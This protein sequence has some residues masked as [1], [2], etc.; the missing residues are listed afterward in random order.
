[1]A[2]I[3][4][5]FNLCASDPEAG[6]ELI[7]FIIREEPEVESE[8]I[9]KFA[10][11]MVYASKGLRIPQGGLGEEF[12]PTDQEL[13]YLE[14]A[15]LRIK[16]IEETAP[17]FLQ[18]L[19]VPE[20]GVCRARVN[21]VVAALERHKPGR[22]QE[23][24]GEMKFKYD[25]FLADLPIEEKVS[26]I[27]NL[28]ESDPDAALRIL[29]S[30]DIENPLLNFSKALA[31]GSKGLFQ[32]T[33]SKP[34]VDITAASGKELREELGL[35]DKQLDY[36]ELALQE[37]KGLEDAHPGFVKEMGT[38]A[39]RKVDVMAIALERC[40][41][42]RVQ[43][44]LGKTKL[45]YFGPERIFKHEDCNLTQQEFQFFRNIFF[46]CRGIAKSALLWLNAIDAEGRRYLAV[47]LFKEPRIFNEKR[48]LSPKAGYVVLYE[49]GSFFSEEEEEPKKPKKKGLFG[50]LFG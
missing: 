26:S 30:R 21:A 42:G 11:A 3:I 45:I 49:D 41:P 28:C 29:E 48:E 15:L 13:N 9:A 47:K 39:E 4:D 24:L 2:E 31:Y 19:A 40:R 1:M 35:T 17:G 8:P 14:L 37:I 12:P 32:M 44:L 34:Q 18:A 50:R 38:L 33:R 25:V 22:V 36:L 7:E 10:K 5:I 27:F 46:T 16:E 20:V 23:L 6:L 43:Q